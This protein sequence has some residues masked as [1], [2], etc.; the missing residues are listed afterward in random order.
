MRASGYQP[1]LIG[2]T[3]IRLL[4]LTVL[5][6]GASDRDMV[7]YYRT[8]C[9]ACHGPDGTGRGPLGLRLPGTS[10]LEPG[11]TLETRARAILEGRRAMPAYRGQL[12]EPEARKM[13]QGVLEPLRK[14]R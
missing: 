10:L 6:L 2:V 7:L 12:T 9:A 8:H 3:R 1:I 5:A 13:V 4:A 14:R 11:P